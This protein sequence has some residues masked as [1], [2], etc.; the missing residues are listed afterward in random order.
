MQFVSCG[1]AIA[2]KCKCS[3]LFCEGYN[4]VV[5]VIK[6]LKTPEKQLSKLLLSRTS[7][8]LEIETTYTNQL[9]RELNGSM[10][11]AEE[12]LRLK[13]LDQ[14]LVICGH[15]LLERCKENELEELVSTIACDDQQIANNVGVLKEMRAALGASKSKWQ[16]T[17][18]VKH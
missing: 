5:N 2:P 4:P 16:K 13:L 10:A 15:R 12:V 1:L 6:L 17:S 9:L 3:P 14:L 8:L 18:L 7:V 11:A